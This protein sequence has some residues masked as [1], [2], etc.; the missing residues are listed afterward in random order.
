MLE[1]SRKTL[2]LEP[3][4]VVELE[5]IMTD[6]DREGAYLFLNKCVYRKLI[7][8]QQKRLKSSLG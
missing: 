2:T 1:T 8:S 7:S 6:A 3:Q 5:R 4:E